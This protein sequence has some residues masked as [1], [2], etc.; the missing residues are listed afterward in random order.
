MFSKEQSISIQTI[1]PDALNASL[2]ELKQEIRDLKSFITNYLP[3]IKESDDTLLLTREEVAKFF[4]INI[5]TV[6][7]WSK[8]GILQPNYVGDRV[9]FKRSEVIAAL[10]PS[11][12][13][14]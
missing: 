9:Y 5:S 13:Q 8:S 10:I 14:F 11:S 4:K 3:T 7:N 1:D 6:R 12:I 2:E